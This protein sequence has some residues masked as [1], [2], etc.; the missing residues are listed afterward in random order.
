MS[1]ERLGVQ[2]THPDKVLF[3][4]A[5]ITKVEFAD[6]TASVASTMVTHL[7][8]RPLM[9][10]RFPRG[11]DESGF[12][13]KD[14]DDALPEWMHR[15]EVAKSGGTIE[16]PLA[17][18]RRAL[19]WLA[20]QDCIT[21]HSW[22]SRQDNL[23]C[24]DRLVIDLDPSS[25]DFDAVRTTAQSLAGLLNAIGLVPY[26]QTTGSRGLHVLAP[27]RGEADFDTVRA[28]A[29]ELAE[30]AAAEDPNHR[31]TEVRKQNRGE[32]IYLDIMRNAYAQTAVAA[33]TVR[34]KASA[35]VATPLSW[36]EVDDPALRPDG[37][38]I[39]DIPAR[40]ARRGDPWAGMGRHARSLAGPRE[41]LAQMRNEHA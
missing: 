17:D 39:S 25:D 31:T 19:V 4:D 33:Y 40:L 38:T 34:A 26:V 32:R 29:G 30:A 7:R 15:V 23:N 10:Q 2:I 9:L 22:L 14:F 13:Q 24:P 41:R 3:P 27:L 36:D 37:F 5:A 1:A 8:G 11:I 16:H 20:N 35:P 18:T 12:V 28:F 21:V 6:Y